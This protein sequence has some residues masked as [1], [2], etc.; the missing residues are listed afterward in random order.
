MCFVYR[1]SVCLPPK[2]PGLS[3]VYLVDIFILMH[4][5]NLTVRY[6]HIYISSCLLHYQFLFLV[7]SDLAK[8]LHVTSYCF[9][10]N[11]CLIIFV[12]ISLCFVEIIKQSNMCAVGR[13]VQTTDGKV[14][15]SELLCLISGCCQKT[16]SE[17]FITRCLLV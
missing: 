10:I 16:R 14:T 1:P 7:P 15:G 5:V 9:L 2:N 8:C 4:P 6:Q 11:S 17:K 12:Y 3:R 13:T